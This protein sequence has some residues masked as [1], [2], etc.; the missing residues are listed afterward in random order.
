MRTRI[1]RANSHFESFFQLLQK[2]FQPGSAVLTVAVHEGKYVTARRPG[3]GFNRCTIAEAFRVADD[4]C[5]CFPSNLIGV[6][7]R[8][9]IDDDNF[10]IRVV[11]ARSR[12]DSADCAAFILGG[13]DYR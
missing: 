2:R 9:V 5:A 1:A 6:I 11:L 8:T 7:S 13:Y 12:H 10:G 4:G 3:T